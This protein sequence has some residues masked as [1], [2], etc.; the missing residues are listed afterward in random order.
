MGIG[1]LPLHEATGFSNTSPP[2]SRNALFL[3]LFLSLSLLIFSGHDLQEQHQY[4]ASS[5]VVSPLYAGL[6]SGQTLIPFRLAVHKS[7]A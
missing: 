7:K 5:V 4:S 3:S 1:R 6:E 2:F